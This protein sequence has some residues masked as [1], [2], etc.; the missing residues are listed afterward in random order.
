MTVAPAVT[1]ALLLLQL[2]SHASST[3]AEDRQIDDDDHHHPVRYSRISAFARSHHHHHH[4]HAVGAGASSPKPRDS[5]FEPGA[6]AQPFALKTLND[7]FVFPDGLPD[8]S[9]VLVHAF[10]NGSGF[11]ECLWGSAESARTLVEAL[12]RNA[13]LIVLSLDESAA[14]DVA[15]LRERVDAAVAHSGRWDLQ[16]RIHYV[17]VQVSSLGNWIPSLLYEWQCDDHNCGLA[18][19]VFHC[20]GWKLPLVVKRLDARYDWLT[21]SWTDQPLRLVDGGDGCGRRRRSGRGDDDGLAGA[22]AW[23]S[24]AGKCSYFTKVHNMM[25][26]GA[27][28][29]LV[30]AEPGASLQDMNCVGRECDTNINI[31]ATMVHDNPDVTAQ[32]RAGVMVNVTFQHTP[33]PAFFFAIDPQGRLAETGWFLYPSFNFLAWQAQWFNYLGGLYMRL[34]DRASVVSVL[35]NAVMQGEDGAAA[36]VLLPP[37]LLT[38]NALEL[39]LALSCPGDRDEACAPWDHTVHLSVC[40]SPDG[41]L[42]STE[43][44]RWITPFRRRVGHWLTD[45]SPLLPLLDAR[46]CNLTLRT[47]PWAKPWRPTLNLRFSRRTQLPDGALFPVKVKPLFT[48]GTFNSSYNKKYLPVLFSIPPATVKVELYAVITGHGSDEHGCGEFC[49]TSHHFVVNRKFTNSITFSNAGTP[50][51]CAQRVTAGVVPNE[52]GTWLYGRNGWCDGQEVEPWRVDITSQVERAASNTIT[53][54]GWFNGSD[55]N[56]KQNPGEI[57]MSSFLVFYSERQR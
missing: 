40:C 44:G 18:Q 7:S 52:H 9:C 38:Y 55:P 6:S 15:W 51:G 48:G 20:T 43:L 56:P 46:T 47:V 39:E 8:N 50:L 10:T 29:V 13:E 45:V 3:N 30:H 33:S 23:V 19:V 41:E 11:L 5:Q 14:A 49:V 32:M 35:D 37:D 16:K 54:Y 24:A 28:G 31:P 36:T 26:S 53:Y 21:G 22:V 25:A 4:H 2:L 17:P 57:T 12:P 1:A 42:C 34:A 27:A